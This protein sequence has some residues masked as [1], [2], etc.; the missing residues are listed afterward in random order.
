MGCIQDDSARRL[1]ER[2]DREA[3]AYRELWA[4]V[5]R[6]AGLDLVRELSQDPA[7][8]IIDVGTGVGTLLPELR[9]AFPAAHVVGVDR[10]RGMLALV[11]AGFAVAAMDATQLGL[12]PNSVDLVLL[13]FMLFHLAKPLDGL[14]EA[15][16]I[17]SVGGRL[18]AVT[19]AGELESR[20]TRIWSECLDARGATKP[21]TAM[22]A[23]HEAVDAPEKMEALVRDA[24]FASVRSW[25]GPLTCTIDRERLLRLRTHLG[26]SKPRYDSL[27]PQDREACMAEARSRM[28]ELAPEDFVAR[29]KVVHTVAS[30]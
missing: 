11:P 29:G 17:L 4:P 13:V 22:E 2:Y 9:T 20:A 15:R 10:S 6:S 25:T 23:R 24:G 16:R 7:R 21:D 18:G 8:R 3:V 26:S 1:T 14:R 27:A 19:W 30:A 5:L 12:A 28:M